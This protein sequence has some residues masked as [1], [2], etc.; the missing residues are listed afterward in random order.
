M[1]CLVII[2]PVSGRKKGLKIFDRL[3]G[4]LKE[5][6]WQAE[7]NVS[8]RR[9][10]I[11]DKARAAELLDFEGV[12]IVGGDGS[13]N[14]FVN[15]MLSRSDGFRI[16]IG[17]IPAGTGNS[18]LH[19]LEQLDPA[20]AIKSILKKKIRNIDLMKVECRDELFYAFNVVGWGLP[21]TINQISERWKFLGGQRYNVASL[22][23]II[24][25]PS[26]PFSLKFGTTELSGDTS[27][28]LACNTIHTGNGMKIAPRARLDDGLL[29]IVLLKG[30]S[31]M[32]LIG[33][34]S[35]IFNGTHLESSLVEYHQVQ[36]LAVED[37]NESTLIIDGQILG[38]TPFSIEIVKQELQILN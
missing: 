34:F 26:W 10:F 25:N 27:F 15:G 35:K 28:F 2:N 1:K 29:D 5:V 16:P 22:Q 17:L 37:D 31:R 11:M 14:E 33:L 6:G 18:L 9:G 36:K 4:L 21:S 7:V 30:A 24:R 12:I 20:K 19:D 38:N 13:L 8:M 3:K 23:E 32:Q